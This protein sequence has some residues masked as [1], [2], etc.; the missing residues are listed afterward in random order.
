MYYV[1]INTAENSN[2]LSL[3]LQVLSRGLSVSRH[4]QTL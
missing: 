3:D 2:V 4:T 1:R